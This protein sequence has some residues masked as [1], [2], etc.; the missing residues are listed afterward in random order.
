ML[1]HSKSE[2]E[3]ISSQIDSEYKSVMAYAASLI[4]LSGV[5][6][7]AILKLYNGQ[8][9]PLREHAII[10]VANVT[11]LVLFIINYKCSAYN[12]LIGYRHLITSEHFDGEITETTFNKHEAIM[13]YDVCMDHL[14]HVYDTK[15][16]SFEFV[17]GEF[18][19][20][21]GIFSDF[22]KSDDDDE[23]RKATVDEFVAQGFP[24][25]IHFT[26]SDLDRVQR[27]DEDI[28][29]HLFG[30]LWPLF[31][32]LVS[33]YQKKN[34]KGSWRFPDYINRMVL[35][36][37]LTQILVVIF[38]T[39]SDIY[40]VRL[41]FFREVSS[42]LLLAQIIFSIILLDCI[43]KLWLQLAF[44]CRR[45]SA[46]FLQF[47]P[48]RMIYFIEICGDMEQ[49]KEDEPRFSI[50]PYYVGIP[51]ERDIQ[52]LKEPRER[53]LLSWTDW[54]KRILIE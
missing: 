54:L 26:N 29:I 52:I 35:Y 10:I 53:P 27:F 48:F 47:L 38:S 44:G 1:E 22:K 32:L 43:S 7:A 21:R 49:V 23:K 2:Y 3:E 12:R 16:F 19:A 14:N 31:K 46:F 50:K 11:L 40:R 17:K 18:Y 13:A 45:S 34:R 9:D 8:D 37:V 33:G 28:S 51:W 4:T 30:R 24:K 41:D 20:R 15:E 36:I 42:V 25:E 39:I 6:F 5:A